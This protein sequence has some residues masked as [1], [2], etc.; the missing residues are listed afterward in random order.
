MNV[1]VSVMLKLV[2]GSRTASDELNPTEFLNQARSYEK[3]RG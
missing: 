1:V 3:A 2:G